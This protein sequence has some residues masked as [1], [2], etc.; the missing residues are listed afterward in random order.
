MTHPAQFGAGLISCG[1]DGVGRHP[2]GG[3]RADALLPSPVPGVGEL[4]FTRAGVKVGYS[5]LAEL[6][7][8]ERRDQI[9]ESCD[10]YSRGGR[11]Q[12]LPASTTA[13][14]TP[15]EFDHRIHRSLRSADLAHV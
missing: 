13:S 5:P 9:N 4:A 12:T 10:K 15:Q 1:C 11:G 8:R 6:C 14:S 2:A 3:K 7:D